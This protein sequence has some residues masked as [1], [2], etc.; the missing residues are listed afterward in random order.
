[1]DAGNVRAGGGRVL[2]GV[3]DRADRGNSKM[4]GL[5][6]LSGAVVVGA[7]LLLVLAFAIFRAIMLIS[8]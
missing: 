1:M 2:A 8:R 3:V 4:N 7:V 6:K 5:A